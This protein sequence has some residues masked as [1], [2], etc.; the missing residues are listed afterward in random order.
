MTAS[1][2]SPRHTLRA[3]QPCNSRGYRHTFVDKYKA[4]SRRRWRDAW[5]RY[6]NPDTSHPHHPGRVRNG[7]GLQRLTSCKVRGQSSY[8]IKERNTCCVLRKLA[9]SFS[10]SEAISPGQPLTFLPS[11]SQLGIGN[12]QRG[13]RAKIYARRREAYAITVMGCLKSRLVQGEFSHVN[14]NS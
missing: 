3:V 8:C 9:S 13:A 4:M 12:T 6:Q 14:L 10:P 11:G 1:R 5:H 7:S 2:T